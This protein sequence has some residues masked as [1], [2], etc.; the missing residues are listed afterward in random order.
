[1]KKTTI[2]S[3]RIVIAILFVITGIIACD[4]GYDCSLNNTAYNKLGFYT[5]SEGT[6]STYN[7]PGPLNISLMIYGKDSLMINHLTDA[8]EISLPMSYTQDYDTI[9]LH[10]EDNFNDSL[11]VRHTNSAYYQSMECGT[12]IQHKIEEIHST[13]VWIDSIA[14]TN[15]NVN[16]NGNENIK[17]YFYK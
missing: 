11:F 2:N 3:L 5:K 4:K 8:S 12:L 1:M 9:I 16:F 17:I 6:E 7:H 13:N 14:I 10:Y 15:Q